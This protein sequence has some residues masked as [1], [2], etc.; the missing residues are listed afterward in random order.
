MNNLTERI[1]RMHRF[2][3]TRKTYDL[4]RRLYYLKKLKKVVLSHESQLI[5][6]LKRD[7]NKPY[8]E[9]YTTEYYVVLEAL[10]TAIKH[11]KQ[12]SQPKRYT[13]FIPTLA[14][15]KVQA[16][17]YGVCAIYS[18]YN[19]PFQLALVPLIGAISAGNCVVIKPSEHTPYTNALLQK[20]VSDTF[21][22]Y[23]ACVLPSSREL[24][25][26]LLQQPLDYIFFTGGTEGGRAIMSKAAANLIPVTLELGGKNPCIVD[27][28]ADLKLAA[29][30]IA[31][32]KYLNGGQTCIA[33]DY[34]LVHEDVKDQFLALLK[35]AIEEMFSEPDDFPTMINEA[36][37][38]KVLKCIHEDA[39]Y[40]GGHFDANKLYI[41]PTILHPV[42]LKDECMQEEIFG[43]ILPVLSFNK[44]S[45]V[46][47]TV[48]RFP[49]PL[50]CYI[51]SRDKYRTHYLTKHLSFGGGAINDTI[52]HIVHPKV[53]FG[54]I[55]YSGMGNYQGHYSF[56]TFSHQQTLLYSTPFEF[57][58]RFPPYSQ[59]LNTLRNFIHL[60]HPL[61]K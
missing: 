43:P 31:W 48:K 10:D 58:L 40:H 18:P 57:P 41:E 56:L 49:K 28:D 9:S 3:N 1:Q 59:K 22:S 24:G 52:M 12:W 26:R 7:F 2:F 19:Y 27:Y 37:Y 30:R 38:I 42:S 29:K 47:E 33:P 17:P 5:D 60:K 16:V 6:A 8:F 11:L 25:E 20:I 36:H 34:V 15:Y 39:I 46:I 51:F 50:A 45:S 14:R 55:G 61:H 35:K 54:G 4:A 23:L 13:S 53:P 32:G 44:L 21:P